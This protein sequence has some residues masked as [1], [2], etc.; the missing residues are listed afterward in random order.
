[1]E[2]AGME[3]RKVSS[4]KNSRHQDNMHR[5]IPFLKG[6]PKRDTAIGREDCINLEIALNTCKTVEAFVIF[7]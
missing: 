4:S 7:M 6:R 5:K 1:M 2:G 3:N